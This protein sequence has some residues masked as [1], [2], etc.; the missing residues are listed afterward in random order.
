MRYFLT[1]QINWKFN[2]IL[3]NSV[4][5]IYKKL[6]WGKGIKGRSQHS[7]LYLELRLRYPSFNLRWDI[8][9][10]TK[11][12]ENLPGYCLIVKLSYTRS[13]DGANEYKVDPN[14]PAY[15][16]YQDSS[17]LSLIWDE[18]FSYRPNQMKIYQDIVWQC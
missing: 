7:C 9:L 11:S 12:N 10:Q 13:S 16:M 6:R 1:H 3:S 2:R 4:T 5:I 14:L 15:I 18:I 17:T 8:F